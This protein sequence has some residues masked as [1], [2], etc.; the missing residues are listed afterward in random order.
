M[1]KD[2]ITLEL[3]SYEVRGKALINLWGGGQGFIEMDPKRFRKEDL[4]KDNILACINDGGFGCESVESAEIEV[5]RVYEHLHREWDR[6]LFA[7][8]MQCQ[9]AHKGITLKKTV[10][11]NH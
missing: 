10:N 9:L 4:S 2:K 6:N 3:T 1:N 7:N 11:E 8:K 5:Y